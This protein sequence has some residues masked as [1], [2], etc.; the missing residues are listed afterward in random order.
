MVILRVALPSLG[1]VC[2]LCGANAQVEQN[3]MFL[4]PV[5]MVYP[6][7]NP[8]AYFLADVLLVLDRLLNYRLIAGP[9][10]QK[11]TTALEEAAKLRRLMSHARQ[12]MR[13][14]VYLSI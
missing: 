10:S 4:K 9:V 7:C 12:L 5:C 14:S 1:L 2:A 8:S 6:G 11:S 13:C 3:F